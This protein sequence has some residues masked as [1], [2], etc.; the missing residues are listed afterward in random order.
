MFYLGIDWSD[1]HHDF[2]VLGDDGSKL[3]SFRIAH[4]PEGFERAHERISRHAS[5]EQVRVAIETKDSLLVDFLLELGYTL[6]FLNPKQTD[7]FRD[8]HR[9]SRSKSDSFDAYVLADALRTDLPLF[10]ALSPLDEPTLRLRVLT[11]TREGLVNRKVAVQ[12]EITTYLKR[13]FPVALQLFGGIDNL[14]A[15]GFLLQYPSHEQARSVSQTRIASIISKQAG[16]SK[17]IAE[18]HAKKAHEL[19]RQEQMSPT[20]PVARSYPL[21]VKSLLRQLLNILKEMEALDADIQD[22]YTSHPNKELI[23]SLPGVADKLGPVIVAEIG[24]DVNRFSDVKTL[25]AY[26]GSCPVTTQSGK[27]RSVHFRRACNKHLR[28]ALHLASQSALSKAGWA[29]ELYDRLRSE[30]K[31]YGRSLRAVA[32]QLLEM[33]YVIL[34]RRTP[35]DEAYHLQ[36][37]AKHGVR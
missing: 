36:M 28:R 27:Y 17:A 21:A 29:R 19:L 3:E 1:K 14:E 33:L 7:R 32:D 12:N 2:C 9:M 20:I 26:A 8:R 25:K 15:I 16:V 10:N 24:A 35:Y 34:I 5:P 23:A 37:K 11:R 4:N 13:Y 22:N 31:S 6:Y 18:R 30:G